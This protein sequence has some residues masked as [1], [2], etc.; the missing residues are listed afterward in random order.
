MQL[1]DIQILIRHGVGRGSTARVI[2]P[3]ASAAFEHWGQYSMRSMAHITAVRSLL[4][5]DSLSKDNRLNQQL[6]DGAD[7]PVL[8]LAKQSGPHSNCNFVQ[9]YNRSAF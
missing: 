5:V 9:C 6:A 1:F 2:Q 4:H 3:A 8:H 7:V